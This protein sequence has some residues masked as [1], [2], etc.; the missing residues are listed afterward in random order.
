MSTDAT[1]GRSLA[2][3]VTTAD[4]RILLVPV[5]HADM[6]LSVPPPSR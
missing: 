5:L 4:S 1:L 6:A 3:D 2:V